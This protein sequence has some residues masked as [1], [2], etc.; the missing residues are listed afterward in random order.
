MLREDAAD[1]IEM[2]GLEDTIK[3][4]MH[5][6]ESPRT[7]SAAGKLTAGILEHAGASKPLKLSGDTFNMAAESYYRDVLRKQNIKEAFFV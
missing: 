1:L 2:M 4:L 6:V 5:R 3:D 7:Y